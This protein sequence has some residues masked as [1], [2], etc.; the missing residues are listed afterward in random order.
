MSGREGKSL[1]LLL[2]RFAAAAVGLKLARC[3]VSESECLYIEDSGSSCRPAS[4]RRANAGEPSAFATSSC[5]G[6]K[7]VGVGW[8]GT[9]TEQAGVW[10]R[11]AGVSEACGP[12]TM[13]QSASRPSG[14]TAVCAHAVLS[15]SAEADGSSSRLTIGVSSGSCGLV[16]VL[17]T[18]SSADA[19]SLA[20]NS[21]TIST[22]AAASSKPSTRSAFLSRLW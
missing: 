13:K 16:A 21:H 3:S 10:C 15:S 5:T 9:S 6:A 19:Y 17:N 20:A 14:A 7:V 22:S 18:G 1:E 12:L 2:V 11:E 8:P 4:G